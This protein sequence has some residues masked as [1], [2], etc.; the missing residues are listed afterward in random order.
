MQKTIPIQIQALGS[1]EIEK[2]DMLDEDM[3][4]L[5]LP[6]LSPDCGNAINGK[7]RGPAVAGR[8][9]LHISDL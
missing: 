2:D 3:G 5:T 8:V 7:R 1:D 4:Y 6:A 9:H